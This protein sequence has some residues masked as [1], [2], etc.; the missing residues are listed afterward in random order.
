MIDNFEICRLLS[1]IT[2]E[3]GLGQFIAV[4]NDIEKR[5]SYFI[6]RFRDKNP[7]D[8][9]FR[10]NID[11]IEVT[12]LIENQSQFFNG[13]ISNNSKIVGYVDSQMQTNHVNVDFDFPLVAF[14]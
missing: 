13:T 7:A 10:A 3:N 2:Q 6:G 5:W 1:K 12:Y 9:I 4:Y 11:G 14:K 8:R